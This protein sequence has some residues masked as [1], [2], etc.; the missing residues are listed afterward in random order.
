MGRND[1]QNGK[2]RFKEVR[3]KGEKWKGGT[4]K[5]DRVIGW[6]CP[7]KCDVMGYGIHA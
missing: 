3:G 5:N 2:D 7:K 4:V 1:K 6:D